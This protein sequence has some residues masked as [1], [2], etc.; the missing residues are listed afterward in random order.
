MKNCDKCITE[1]DYLS[2]TDGCDA[3]DVLCPWEAATQAPDPIMDDPI[4]YE[5]CIISGN[6]IDRRSLG[7]VSRVAGTSFIEAKAMLADPRRTIFS[8]RADEVLEKKR[9]LDDARIKYE[10]SPEFPY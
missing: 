2:Q 3:S 7:A 10:I 5:I 8:G 4:D 9:I 6:E 1:A